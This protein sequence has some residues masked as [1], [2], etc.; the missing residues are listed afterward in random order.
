MTNKPQIKLSETVVLI[1]AAFLNFVIMDMKRYFEETLQRTL[2]EIDLSMLTTYLTLDAGIVEGKNEVQFLFVYDKDSNKLQNCQPSDL[3]NELNG[4]AF[5]SPYGEYL[6][7]SV[8]S[9]GMVSREALFLDLLS[10][11]SD[12][13]DVKKMII[14]SFNEEY[15]DKVTTVLSEVKEKEIIQFRMNEPQI[16]VE[17]KWD[18]LA[19]PVMQALGIRADEL[20]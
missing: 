15:G 12:S 5:Q 7:A 18:M 1:D 8:P 19:F 4:V 3:K 6:F 2:Q 20:Q 16:P 9:E 11:I 10:I 13:A 14:I 17:Y